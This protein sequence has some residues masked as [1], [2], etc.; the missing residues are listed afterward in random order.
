MSPYNQ[1][2]RSYHDILLSW[3]LE[4]FW[5]GYGRTE[6][7]MQRSR[8]TRRPL[9]PPV[10]DLPWCEGL[11]SYTGEAGRPTWISKAVCTMYVLIMQVK[12]GF[13]KT[14]TVVSYEDPE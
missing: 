3:L 13:D 12:V 14:R 4:L 5:T 7:G 9:C 10:R 8:L 11:F 6:Y 1:Q 2:G